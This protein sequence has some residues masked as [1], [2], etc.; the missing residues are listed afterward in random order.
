MTDFLMTKEEGDRFLH[1]YR[2]VKNT[3]QFS[4]APHLKKKNKCYEVYTKMVVSSQIML[5]QPKY[6]L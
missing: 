4:R 2:V 5:F 1:S 6:F 3:L